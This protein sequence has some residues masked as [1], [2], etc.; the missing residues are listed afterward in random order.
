MRLQSTS[1]TCG[2]VAVVNAIAALDDTEFAEEVVRELAGTTA[3][4][5]TNPRQIRQAIKKLG[6][7]TE[8][9]DAP[10]HL[11]WRLLR[12]YLAE[13]IP[14]IMSVDKDSHWITAVGLIGERV[15]LADSADGETVVSRDAWSVLRR[16]ANRKGVCF[17]LAVLSLGKS[18]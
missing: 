1:F 7:T 17:G 8:K 2:P 3:T 18:D 15:L 16:W 6:Y 5:G 4:H 9:F 11:A 13:G 12:G 10:S 14:V